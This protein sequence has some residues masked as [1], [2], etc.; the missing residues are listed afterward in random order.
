MNNGEDDDDN[1]EEEDGFVWFEILVLL[2]GCRIIFRAPNTSTSESF[3][4][5]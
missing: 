4:K 5:T 1:E 2:L 3:E